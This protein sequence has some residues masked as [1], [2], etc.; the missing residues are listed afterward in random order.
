DRVLPAAGRTLI[1]RQETVYSGVDRSESL[2]ARKKNIR[3]RWE[4]SPNILTIT[5]GFGGTM[6]EYTLN[7][8]GYTR[9]IGS[10]NPE[11]QVSLSW[12]RDINTLFAVSTGI[13]FAKRSVQ[14]N[15]DSDEW[16]QSWTAAVFTGPRLVF[17]DL[18]TDIL[19]GINAQLKYIPQSTHSWVD[20]GSR[21]ADMGS[22][23][24]LELP[25]STGFRY[26]FNN[27][28]DTIPFFLSGGLEISF[29]GYR[30]D[31][32]G[33][34]QSEMSGTTMILSIGLGIRL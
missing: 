30:F 2:I 28:I 7:D 24:V 13:T 26:Y 32:G 9:K 15:L 5:G 27:R 33:N 8:N 23:L 4:S 25:M 17:R 18:N 20:G 16:S 6:E 31:L 19:I 12:D 22:F 29:L 21:Q 11:P 10:G 14:L 34:N 3:K 1:T